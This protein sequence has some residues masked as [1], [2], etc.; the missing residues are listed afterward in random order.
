VRQ[1]LI[2]DALI[3]E[4]RM[5]YRTI[6]DRADLIP[7]IERSLELL[8]PDGC[9][10]S[11]CQRSRS[12][13]DISPRP[14]CRLSCPCWA[15]C[16]SVRDVPSEYERAPTTHQNG[17]NVQLAPDN[18]FAMLGPHRAIML[19][20]GMGVTG[21]SRNTWSMNE[22]SGT[23]LPLATICPALLMSTA[24]VSRT[25][26]LSGSPGAIKLFKSNV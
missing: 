4:Y 18:S 8:A 23:N 26:L 22:R 1:E 11:R 20:Y 6:Y 13:K 10:G 19:G 25:L 3:T 21:V 24:P 17:L 7:F 2:P 9:R 15:A 16:E 14:T 5:R 12:G